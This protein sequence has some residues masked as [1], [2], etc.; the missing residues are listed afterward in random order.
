MYLRET[1]RERER[2]KGSSV[3]LS[4]SPIYASLDFPNAGLFSAFHD[5]KSLEHFSPEQII[6]ESPRKSAMLISL[7]IID[8]FQSAAEVFSID[9]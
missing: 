6:L 2:D 4:I 5:A 3:T 8:L 7:L 9:N 1:E